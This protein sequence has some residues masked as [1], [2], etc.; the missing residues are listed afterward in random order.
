MAIAKEAGRAGASTLG[1]RVR[2][3]R[4]ELGLSQAQLAGD[5]LTKGFIS[6]LESGLVRPS[7]RSLQV[8][9]TRLAKPLD[10]FLGD[11][12]LA[13]GKRVAF[14][15]L[16]AET[17]VERKDWAAVREQVGRALAEDPEP[18][19]RARFLLFLAEAEAAA[20][21]YERTFE[22]VSSALGLVDVTTDA[23]LV[24]SLLFVRGSTYGESG[25]LVA[26]TEAL[27][28]CR[29]TVERY[30]VLD[31]RLR[32]RLMVALGTAYRR[33]KRSS[34][35]LTSYEAALAT[36]TRASELTIAARG[37]MGIAATHYDAG[38]ADAAISSYRRALDLFQR[39]SDVDFEL[40]A[41]QSIGIVQFEKGE[42]AAA[43]ASAQ[44]A[45]ARALEV[46]DA[47][48]AAVAEVILAR[49]ALVE[50]DPDASLVKAQHGERIL[51]E[52]GDR[53]QQADAL[54][55]IGAAQEAL[56][57]HSEAD[58][59]YRGSLDLYTTVGDLADRSGMA[60]EYARVLKARGDMDAAFAMLEL[61]RGALAAR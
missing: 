24:A 54:G 25:Q 5:E 42:T 6:Q 7:I 61:A 36:A 33:L 41:L 39:V 56:G 32:S 1:E 45:M 58:A 26:A 46:G 8:I 23:H 19:E 38:E 17:A 10:Y 11:E 31:P 52:A 15:R 50:G 29:D 47:H 18:R 22:L 40:N 12:P 60:A 44:R 48:W 57:R 34:K 13:T 37:Y 14:H 51:S 35:A 55:A 2:A 20:A 21:S 4:K 28:T 49:V 30:E 53:I 3:A 59:A 43:K 27:E 9:A 16:A